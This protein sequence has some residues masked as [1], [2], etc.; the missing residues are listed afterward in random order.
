MQLQNNLWTPPKATL[1]SAESSVSQ[2]ILMEENQKDV[3]QLLFLLWN[4]DGTC[5]I[6]LIASVSCA[7]PIM[8][9]LVAV[10]VHGA[11]VVIVIHND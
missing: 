9:A 3:D 8:I 2:S 4:H 5:T 7:I 6:T 1:C 11:V 10:I